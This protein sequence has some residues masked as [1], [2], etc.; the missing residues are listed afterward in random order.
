MSPIDGARKSAVVPPHS[1]HWACA[2]RPPWQH[3]TRS[4]H[5]LRH[6]GVRVPNFEIARTPV[7]RPGRASSHSKRA[8]RRRRWGGREGAS[9]KTSPWHSKLPSDRRVYHDET[10]C[11]EGNNIEPRNRFEGRGRG[12]SARAAARSA[13]RGLNRGRAAGFSPVARLVSPNPPS[14]RGAPLGRAIVAR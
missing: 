3:Q 4:V 8:Y 14:R 1:A 2:R 12:R 5:P 13:A 6:E 11:T 9:M 10:R 7:V